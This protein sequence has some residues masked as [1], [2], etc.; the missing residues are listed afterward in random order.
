M[1]AAAL[2]NNRYPSVVPFHQSL[3]IEITTLELH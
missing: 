1:K 3:F 2:S